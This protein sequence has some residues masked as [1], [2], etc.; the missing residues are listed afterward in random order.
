MKLSSLG[1][2]F[3]ALPAVHCIKQHF[4]AEIHW[5]VQKEYE[6]LV[7]CFTDVDR[8]IAVSRRGFL[9]N[10]SG[11]AADIRKCEYDMVI[12]MQGLLKSAIVARIAKG[13]ERIGPSFHR[14]GAALFY[15]RVAGRR[16]LDRHAVDQ[17]MDVVRMLGAPATR[18]EFPVRFPDVQVTG[19]RP[20]VALLPVSRWPSKNWPAES[21]AAAAG[22]IREKRGGS[23]FVLGG[24]GEA[25]VC[26]GLQRS[27]G[28]GAVSMA[29]RLSLP[30]LGGFLKQMDLLIAN[31]SGPVHMAAVV[32]TPAV[33]IFGPTDPRRTGPYGQKHKVLSAEMDCRPCFSRACRFG[34]PKC[35]AAV[36]ADQVAEVALKILR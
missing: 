27:I 12:D 15:H 1:D 5:A 26:A 35:M 31:D 19:R 23:F 14:E 16:D 11:L 32:G 21:F 29:G 17:I 36:T 33:V 24:A 8:V 6:A 30:A 34:E 13:R 7:K 4:H 9:R 25:D 22:K 2:L 20:R 18:V 10:L 3:H 28:E